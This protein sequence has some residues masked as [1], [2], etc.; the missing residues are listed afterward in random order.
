GLP[1][2]NSGT[3]YASFTISL[4]NP[5]FQ[6]TVIQYTTADGTAVAGRD[7]VATSGSVV[8]GA[9]QT[10]AWVNVGVLGNKIVEP[11]KTFA[12]V[13]TNGGAAILPP[14]TQGTCTIINDD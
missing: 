5:S 12:L 9:G 2:G 11:N 1:E 3:S 6:S 4:S 13:I 7:Y 10:S 14:G 8:I